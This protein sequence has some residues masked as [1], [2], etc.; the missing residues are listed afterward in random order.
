MIVQTQPTGYD[1]VSQDE[2]GSDDDQTSATVV[3]N[4][5]TLT[6]DETDADKQDTNN[7]FVEAVPS[8]S[9]VK[10]ITGVVDVN[11]NGI[12]D[13]GDRIEYAFEVYNTGNTNLVNITVSDTKLGMNS[14]AC[15]AGPLAPDD[16]VVCSAAGSY[17]IQDADTLAGYVVNSAT[18]NAMGQSIVDASA[19]SVV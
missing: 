12:T 5:L 9:L 17:I 16:T 7:D 11:T 6:L 19:G 10:S 18:T 2:G 8:M 14:A 3:I 4:T 15:N 1:N 13:A